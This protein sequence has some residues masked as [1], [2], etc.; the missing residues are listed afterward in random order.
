MRS[1]VTAV[2][3]EWVQWGSNVVEWTCV[4]HVSA[5]WKGIRVRCQQQAAVSVFEMTA[6]WRHCLCQSDTV[7]VVMFP[8][9]W[10][11]SLNTPVAV[12]AR[13]TTAGFVQTALIVHICSAV[14]IFSVA[15]TP[16]LLDS[17]WTSSGAFSYLISSFKLVWR[18]P[19]KLWHGPN[20]HTSPVICGMVCLWCESKADQPQDCVIVDIWFYDKS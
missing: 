8:D 17:V 2:S 20:D 16:N 13:G 7:F 4:I 15:F 12:S 14:M 3:Y 5:V 11:S 1:R 6:A 18:M 9:C 10:W 19:F